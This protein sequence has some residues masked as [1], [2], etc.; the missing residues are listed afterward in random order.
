MSETT[1]TQCSAAIPQPSAIVVC[2]ACGEAATAQDKFCEACGNPLAPSPQA[3]SSNL[4]V[5]VTEAKCSF[6]Q[7]AISDEFCNECGKQ[8]KFP[9]RDRIEQELPGV[10]GVTDLGLRHTRNEDAMAFTCVP[11]RDARVLIVCD[12]TSTAQNSDIASQ[13]ACDAALATLVTALQAGDDIAEAMKNAGTAAQNAVMTVAYNAQEAAK[14]SRRGLPACTF[15]AVVV[16]GNKQVITGTIGDSRAYFIGETA[17]LQLSQDDSWAAE[18]VR[19]GRLTLEQAMA[20]P[21]AHAITEWLGAD[22]QPEATVSLLELP[23]KGAV[24]VCSDGLWNYAD[25]ADLIAAEASKCGVHAAP[26]AVAIGLT[27]FAKQ[28]GG[29]DNITVVVAPIG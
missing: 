1:P 21:Q 20:D 26:L 28:A 11:E 3:D 6:C 5:T 12:G 7:G 10:A 14:N 24:I 22:N 18:E 17:N 27:E 8:R 15:V 13:L 9:L 29:H 2:S 19:A 16:L 4:A 23:E 25:G